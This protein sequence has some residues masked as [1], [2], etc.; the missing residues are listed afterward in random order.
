MNVNELLHLGKLAAQ[1]LGAQWLGWGAVEDF[2][3]PCWIC[4]TIRTAILIFFLGALLYVSP[5]VF[6]V[7]AVAW[8]AYSA[9]TGKGWAGAFLHEQLAK[10]FKP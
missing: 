1:C 6:T 9:I 5:L 10:V 2:C 7:L 8:A 3:G 4:F